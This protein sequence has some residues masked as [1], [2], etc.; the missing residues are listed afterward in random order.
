MKSLSIL[1]IPSIAILLSGCGSGP[2]PVY[3]GGAVYGA[4]D[5]GPGPYGPGPN[6]QPG[7]Y[8]NGTVYIQGVPSWYHHS[9]QYSQESQY[10]RRVTDVNDVNVNRTDVN[11]RT[12]NNTTVNNTRVNNRNI[13]R[14]NINRTNVNRTNLNVK[15]V[16][17]VT[18]RP[19]ARPTPNP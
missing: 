5:Y 19:R 9:N 3:G 11:N 1:L 10:N 2:G 4:V 14:T 6:P 17:A 13:R 7:Y 8:W 16:K 15:N 12:V 18:K